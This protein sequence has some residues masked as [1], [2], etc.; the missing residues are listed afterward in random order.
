MAQ[1]THQP[2]ALLAAPPTA[3]A[4]GRR[5]YLA[6]NLNAELF[7]IDILQIREIIEFGIITPVPMAPPSVRGIINLRGAVVPVIDLAVRFNRDATTVTRR[8]CIVITEIDLDG[9]PLVLGVLVDTVNEVLEIPP[10]D[11]EPPPAFGTRIRNDFIAGMGRVGGSFVILLNLPRV[12]SLD[13]LGQLTELA[14]TD[15]QVA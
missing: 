8:T 3:G 15:L 9:Q 7:A 13:E 10:A 14:E 12:L 6:F 4:D 11:I 5:Q 2:P 1:Q